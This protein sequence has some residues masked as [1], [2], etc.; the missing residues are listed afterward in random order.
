MD[1]LLLSRLVV[2]LVVLGALGFVIYRRRYQKAISNI[3]S[4][5]VGIG[6]FLL[7]PMLGFFGAILYTGLNM[8]TA[9][10]GINGIRLTLISESEVFGSLRPVIVLSTMFGIAVMVSAALC[11]YFIFARR[12][13]V[14]Y[15]ATLHY[16]VLF[17]ASLVE[18]WGD[19]VIRST[20]PNT[21][22]DP[23]VITG[24][25][26]SVITALIWIPYFHL[27]QRVRNT[28]E[29]GSVSLKA[30]NS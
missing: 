30:T 19:S 7:L 13:G 3:N 23:A 21:P 24:V 8:Y 4:P 26:R 25:G 2:M 17:L 16:M 28:F 22:M 27:S 18:L 1:T 12:S 10:N 6:G 20:I 29:S 9:F 15:V 5:P 11:L 14:K